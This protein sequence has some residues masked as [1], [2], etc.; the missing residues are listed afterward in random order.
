[1]TAAGSGP[2]SDWGRAGRE[3]PVA[4]PT[5]QTGCGISR[6][7]FWRSGT[8]LEIPGAILRTQSFGREL[9]PRF[10]A[11]KNCGGISRGVFSGF[12]IGDGNPGPDSRAPK[13][14]A[15][16][17]GT[18]LGIGKRLRKLSQGFSTSDNRSGTFRTAFPGVRIGRG[19]SRL[20]FGAGRIR[21]RFRGADC[22]MSRI[23]TRI[24]GP[25]GPAVQTSPRALGF[26][27]HDFAHRARG[28]R[29]GPPGLPTGRCN[30]MG[31][32]T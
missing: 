19:I 21:A 5:V 27:V 29:T 12:P 2:A 26:R 13:R 23:G 28:R 24:L 25:P 22:C 4:L 31:G 15:G 11:V 16:F 20:D 18:I 1:M 8:A 30:G 6:G 17:P 3:K 10:S 14:A 32:S 9:P 7:D